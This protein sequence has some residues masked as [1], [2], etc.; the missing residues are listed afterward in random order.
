MA[1]DTLGIEEIGYMTLPSNVPAMPGLEENTTTHFIINLPRPMDFTSGKRFEVG[2]SEIAFPHSWDTSFPTNQCLYEIGVADLTKP[3]HL[4]VTKRYKACVP[5]KATE[6][7][8]THV[9]GL[10]KAL[11]NR[12]PKK[13]LG[14][15]KLDV[16]KDDWEFYWRGEFKILNKRVHIILCEGERIVLNENLAK[17]LGFKKTTYNFTE[18][19]LSERRCGEDFQETGKDKKEDLDKSATANATA[20][21]EESRPF[22]SHDFDEPTPPG[23]KANIERDRAVQTNSRDGIASRPVSNSEAREGARPATNDH[24]RLEPSTDQ[25]GEPPATSSEPIGT[26]SLVDRKGDPLPTANGEQGSNSGRDQATTAS[27][28]LAGG[29]RRVKR[30]RHK[31]RRKRTAKRRKRQK[32]ENSEQTEE[33]EC[34]EGSGE[35]QEEEEPWE[36]EALASKNNKYKI[37][38]EGLPHLSFDKNVIFVYSNL[39]KP[40]FCGDSFYPLLRT[41]PVS[42]EDRGK[43]VSKTFERIH[44]L[45]LSGNFFNQIEVDLRFEDGKRIP[46]QFGKVVVTLHFREHNAKP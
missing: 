12:R 22:A 36:K 28:E 6:K 26:P 13:W 5:R 38:A 9:E 18:G 8:Y 23:R 33:L 34:D 10:V 40:T 42:P 31:Q 27:P 25:H 1:D 37:R 41:V 24:T 46:F 21:A 16:Q 2:L 11:N 45:P 17:A 19:E 30:R 14:K 43:Y 32:E 15:S 39:V 3:Q 44:Y 35:E 4:Q 29:Q 20:N 7:S